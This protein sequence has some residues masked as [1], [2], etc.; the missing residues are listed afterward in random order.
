MSVSVKKEV[1]VLLDCVI[2]NVS[3]YNGVTEQFL[4]SKIRLEN[5]REGEALEL[6]S[7]LLA[8]L[9]GLHDEEVV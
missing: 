4:D 1:P 5:H 2:Q 3:D 8:K 6:K 9:S 7:F